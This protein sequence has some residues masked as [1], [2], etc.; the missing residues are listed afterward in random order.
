MTLTLVRRLTATFAAFFIIAGLSLLFTR[1]GS[2]AAVWPANAILLAILLR[3]ES[4]VRTPLAVAAWLANL[5]ANVMAGDGLGLASL[6]SCLNVIEVA[7]AVSILT[8]LVRA[9]LDLTQGRHL[10]AFLAV[11]ITAPLP[12]AGIAAVALSRPSEPWLDPFLTWWSADALGLLIFAPAALIL[13]QRSGAELL[14]RRARRRT[15]LNA[16]LLLAALSVTF[17]QDSQPLLFLIP[18]CLVLIT[19]Q[20]GLAGAAWGMLITATF[21]VVAFLNGLGPTTLAAGDQNDQ[22][23]TL[24]FFLAFLVLATL[25]L[26]SVL[27][28]RERLERRLSTERETQRHLADRLA[29]GQVVTRLAQHTAGVGY[30]V[31]RPSTR[32]TTWSDYMYALYGL[33][34]DGEIPPFDDVLQRFHPD[35]RDAARSHV[36]ASLQTGTDHV[37]ELRVDTST[38]QRTLMA[39]TRLAEM[40]DGDM[41]VL[42]VM[43]DVTEMR[44]AEAAVIESEARYRQLADTVPDM[45]LR[46]DRGV[47]TYASPACRRYGYEPE[48]LVGREISDFIHP[49]DVAGSM[50][51]MMDLQE[52]GAID[53]ALRREQRMR[54]ADGGWVWLEG[55]PRQVRNDKGEVS[56]IINVLRDVTRRRA[57]EDELITARGLAERAAQV[58][59]DFMSNMSHELRTPLTAIIGFS[60]LLRATAKLDTREADFV[61]RIDRAGKALLELVN[62]VLDFSKVEAGQLVLES[63]P[64]SLN[65]VVDEA[66]NLVLP[67]AEAKGLVLTAELDP[68]GCEFV[69][70]RARLRQVLVNLVGNAVKFTTTGSVAIRAEPDGDGRLRVEIR[71]TGPGIPVE[72][73]ALI[74]ERYTQADGSTTRSHGGTGLGLAISKGFVEAMGGE[75][76]VESAVGAG[77]TFWFTIAAPPVDTRT[78]TQSVSPD[79]RRRKTS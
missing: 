71:D 16:A 70:D 17:L 2:I 73:R 62:Q 59:T 77:S 4:N 63:S 22:L 44:R 35:D 29:A 41:A 65:A 76:G 10:M 52:G 15:S 51:R 14:S 56:E 9:P 5:A 46:L 21:A 55:N 19:F 25:P 42:G 58:K 30:W 67:Q 7:L 24:Q 13:A 48:D 31:Y 75:I 50:Q 54:L 43:V 47:I 36:L 49:D 12:I 33:E 68:D 74:F 26:A 79:D 38:S 1:Q 18:P 40:P 72:R 8:R 20:L 23:R 32:T 45:I 28:A 39:R 53:P 61:H 27:G 66:I 34:N 78:R 69:G 64:I 3:A 11:A 57:L 6:L 60:S 37:L